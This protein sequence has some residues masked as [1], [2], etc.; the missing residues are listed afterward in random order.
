LPVLKNARCIFFI[1]TGASKADI[2]PRVLFPADNSQL[3]AAMV[4]PQKNAVRW[5]L[6]TAAAEKI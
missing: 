1:A 6:D 3:P 2:L 5:Y 4:Y